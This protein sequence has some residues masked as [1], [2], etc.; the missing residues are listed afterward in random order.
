MA[1]PIPREPP[2]TRTIRPSSDMRMGGKLSRRAGW[3]RYPPRDLTRRS[4]MRAADRWAV[5]KGPSRPDPEPRGEV[6]RLVFAGYELDPPRCRF[7]YRYER[8]TYARV[9]TFGG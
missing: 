2:V 9:L 4:A 7:V 1:R 6:R 5:L 3:L 8:A